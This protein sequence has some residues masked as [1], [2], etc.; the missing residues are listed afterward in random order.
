MKCLLKVVL[1]AVRTSLRNPDRSLF[2]N[3]N[4]DFATIVENN[5]LASESSSTVRD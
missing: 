1:T 2:E 5:R 3:E 4:M